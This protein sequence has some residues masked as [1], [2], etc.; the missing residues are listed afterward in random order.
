L[1]V[2]RSSVAWWPDSGAT[3]STLGWLFMRSSA[4]AL[5]V[6][7]LKRSRRQKGLFSAT[8]SCTATSTPSTVAEVMLKGGFSYSLASRCSRSKPADT[9]SASGMCA[10]GDSGWS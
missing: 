7:R 8:C 4:R 5:S 10:K 9:R 3:T 6:K 1:T 2:S